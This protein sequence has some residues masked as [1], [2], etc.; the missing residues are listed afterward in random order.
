MPCP[1]MGP[2]QRPGQ[3]LV[4]LHLRV[5]LFRKMT[6][7]MSKSVLHKDA[8]THPKREDFP[9]ETLAARTW[10]PLEAVAPSSL[11]LSSP[12]LLV[13]VLGCVPGEQMYYSMV[14]TPIP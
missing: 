14:F 10:K 7:H 8:Q 11:S 2:S 13:N 4:N 3:K 1:F 5:V 6:H 12:T 9:L